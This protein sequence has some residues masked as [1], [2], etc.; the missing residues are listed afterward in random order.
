MTLRTKRLLKKLLPNDADGDDDSDNDDDSDD[1]EDDVRAIGKEKKKKK[2]DKTDKSMHFSFLFVSFL[3]TNIFFS[4]SIVTA[5]LDYIGGLPNSSCPSSSTEV[6]ATI[7][8]VVCIVI[9]FYF[10]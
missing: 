2:K 9:L 10:I 3:L 6:T 4:Y 1:D 5:A 8:Y 7:E